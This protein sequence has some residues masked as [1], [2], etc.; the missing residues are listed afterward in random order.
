IVKNAEFLHGNYGLLALLPSAAHPLKVEN[1]DFKHCITGLRV[2]GKNLEL[3]TSRLDSN[4]VGLKIDAATASCDIRNS[5]FNRNSLLGIEFSGQSTAA[6]YFHESQSRYSGTGILASGNCPVRLT[7][8]SISNNTVGLDAYDVDIL[9][10]GEA[11]NDFTANQIGISISDVKH[12]ILE[13][14]YNNFATSTTYLYGAFADN[15]NLIY[16]GTNYKL[17]VQNNR[18]PAEHGLVAVDLLTYSAAPVML[19]NWQPLSAFATLCPLAA[20]ASLDSVML[21]NAT[22]TLPVETSYQNGKLPIVVA[23][24]I[25]DMTDDLAGVAN[26]DEEAVAKLGEIFSFVRTNYTYRSAVHY[27]AYELSEEEV[28]LMRFAI[29]KALKALGNAYR[30]ELLE[31]NRAVNETEVSEQLQTVQ[32]ELDNQLYYYNQDYDEERW[33]YNKLA[34]AQAYRSGEHYDYALEQL[35]GISTEDGKLEGIRDYW[36]CI[37]EAEADFILEITDATQYLEALDECVLNAP[38]LRRRSPGPGIP[39][40]LIGQPSNQINYTLYPNPSNGLLTVSSN[41]SLKGTS[42]R[43][44]D[45]QGTVHLS[46]SISLEG[47]TNTFDA[48]MLSNGIYFLQLYNSS[49][50]PHTLKF[51][52]VK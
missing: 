52:L 24:A 11:R 16:D 3:K 37:C 6:L 44:S 32:E 31:P 30:Y 27:M 18:L 45:M 17:N 42:Y 28:E 14:G 5:Q 26:R 39:V 21:G 1:S 12:F 13:N 25:S 7:C 47:G 40:E 41:I 23:T 46:G 29:N 36:S 8:S 19:H 4:T 51:T 15:P 20:L 33:F 38:E 2:N 34:K 48:S 43:L 22:T 9:L 50:P 35:A 10:G 49:N